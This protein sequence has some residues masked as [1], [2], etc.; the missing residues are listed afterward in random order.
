MKYQFLHN[1]TIIDW[2]LEKIT[3]YRTQMLWF[4]GG[5][6]NGFNHFGGNFAICITTLSGYIIYHNDFIS[7]NSSYK[8]LYNHTHTHKC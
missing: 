2:L 4:I 3:V 7:K 6:L 5:N 8:Y 1:I